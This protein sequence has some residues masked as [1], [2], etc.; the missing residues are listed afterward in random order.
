MRASIASFVRKADTARKFKGCI[1]D[2]E[3]SASLLGQPERAVG[4]VGGAAQP[5]LVRNENV[6]A[7]PAP[8]PCDA[9][10]SPDADSSGGS[11]RA[12]KR[13]EAPAGKEKAAEDLGVKRKRLLKK[14]DS[15][16]REDDNEQALNTHADLI[17]KCDDAVKAGVFHSDIPQMGTLHFWASQVA[18]SL[19]ETAATPENP[20][21]EVTRRDSTTDLVLQTF[22]K[23][24]V[25]VMLDS[26]CFRS[27]APLSALLTTLKG[28]GVV[29][30]KLS[31][32]LTNLSKVDAAEPNLD[33]SSLSTVTSGTALGIQARM[34]L[35]S[36]ALYFDFLAVRAE[37]LVAAA[38]KAGS[39][40]Q[41]H[42]LLTAADSAKA[43]G[44]D[45]TPEQIRGAVDDAVSIIG[46]GVSAGSALSF[47]LGV[48]RRVALARKYTVV[49]DDLPWGVVLFFTDIGTECPKQTTWAQFDAVV[50]LVIS[51]GLL[52]QVTNP[53]AKLVLDFIAQ[54]RH[55][56]KDQLWVDTLCKCAAGARIN[57]TWPTKFNVDAVD[58][59]CLP[60]VNKR[61][62]A[63]FS[64][65]K[66]PDWAVELSVACQ[67]RE[68]EGIKEAQ[69]AAAAAGQPALEDHHD[70]DRPW[71][72]GDIVRLKSTNRK[73]NGYLAQV[74][75]VTKAYLKVCMQDGP[76]AQQH[77]RA[78]P[79]HCTLYFA[80][81]LAGAAGEKPAEAAADAKEVS[82]E[83]VAP[84][85]TAAATSQVLVPKDDAAAS[86]RALVPRDTAAAVKALYGEKK[87]E[88]D[89][90]ES[91]EEVSETED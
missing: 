78:Q 33:T 75:A 30:P 91:V 73:V 41:R 61:V 20:S 59:K 76:N 85:D 79:K 19:P 6:A 62:A 86:S 14:Y 7:Q 17:R 44:G 70:P 60:V 83:A 8:V 40:K 37:A 21:G 74:E 66:P 10:P 77:T 15:S 56:L 13:E 67:R 27:L 31:E 63:L 65:T 58:P 72:V 53:F 48:A 82:S 46:S 57:A 71:V 49:E 87:L 18:A 54:T 38:E 90:D 52:K 39:L 4:D 89:D 2:G 34:R 26:R 81:T 55:A 42:S 23:Y 16:D 51:H 25:T 64:N 35:Y 24:M 68:Q 1:D 36:S 32:A 29:A 47:A 43:A 3:P 50:A 84:T 80:S 9:A 45:S 69:A 5:A 28:K 22:G 88:E 12:K 11:K